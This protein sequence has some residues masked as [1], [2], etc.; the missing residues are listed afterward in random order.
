[1]PDHP[2]I[3]PRVYVTERGGCI[4]DRFIV[5]YHNEVKHPMVGSSTSSVVLMRNTTNFEYTADQLVAFMSGMA[6]A[7]KGALLDIHPD[8]GVTIE[9]VTEEYDVLR[10]LILKPDGAWDWEFPLGY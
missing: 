2:V 6:W 5:R 4:P 10:R 1:M 8:S 9:A 3:P 7:C